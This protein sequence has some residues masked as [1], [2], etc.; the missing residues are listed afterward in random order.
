MFT[1]AQVQAY[2]DANPQI[3]DSTA[4]WLQQQGEN[5]SVYQWVMDD[6]NQNPGSAHLGQ[7]QQWQASQATPAGTAT[8]STGGTPIANVTLADALAELNQDPDF[9]ALPDD[10]KSEIAQFA[11]DHGLAAAAQEMATRATAADQDPQFADA[12]AA[13]GRWAGKAKTNAP[14]VDGTNNQGGTTNPDGSTTLPLEQDLLNQYL[15]G[16][17]SDADHDRVRRELVDKLGQQAVDDFEAARNALSPEENA[18]RLAEE[19]AQA[20]KT[21]TGISES[22]ATSAADQ[23]R[24]LQD[25]IAQMQTNLS[26][27]Q[28]EK[29][30]ALQDQ[31]TSLLGN[32]DTLDATQKATLAQQI[33]T[34]QKD[35]EDSITSQRQNLTTEVAALR[36]A[37]DANSQARAAALQKELDGLNA[38]QQPLAQA[39]LDSANALATAVN[40]GLQSTEDQLTATRA[41]QGYLGSS[42]FDAANL[43][44]AGITAR[45]QAAQA[46]GSARE[47]NAQDVRDIGVH[48]A[49]AGRSIADE[50]AGNLLGISGHEAT[51]GRTLADLLATGTQGIGDTGAAGLADIQKSTAAGKFN[52]G[53][54]GAAQ[55][56]ADQ[57]FGSTQKQALADALA[58][59]GGSIGSTLALQQQ[60]ARDAALAARQGYFDNAYTRGQGGILSRAN[61]GNN[62][63]A[64]LTALDNYGNSGLNRTL[65][66]LNWWSTGQTQAPTAGYVPVTADNS[67]NDLSNLG[68]GLLGAGLNVGNA[69]KW[70]TTPTTTA[71]TTPATTTGFDSGA[72]DF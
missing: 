69:N 11:I 32:L 63:A 28:A 48:G 7:F 12:R 8:P 66:T 29:A 4:Q 38:A 57:V 59:G 54:T 24:A 67:G 49:T 68:A 27:A 6:M 60:A 64:N 52:V 46:L 21:G 19:L 65:N 39:R 22:A 31:I 40:L 35:L 13:L 17:L 1:Q 10:W 34:T 45:Q 43:A 55:T 36:S 70:W 62:L 25:S 72:W 30:K 5:R 51:G 3:R 47:Q 37:A 71:A 42:T 53:N 50:L 16:L 14:L 2:L 58:K 18:R 56:Y 33:A 26:G 41:K 20:D 23:L 9:A 61:L 44:R 15:A